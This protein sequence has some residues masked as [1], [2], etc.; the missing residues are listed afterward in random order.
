[1]Q[2]PSAPLGPPAP[3]PPNSPGRAQGELGTYTRTMPE[4][5]SDPSPLPCP[6]QPST[7]FICSRDVAHPVASKFVTLCLELPTLYPTPTH[8][9]TPVP[10]F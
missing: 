1:M 5:P 9:L 4:T 8:T 3:D 6:P 2:G 10:Q 7:R